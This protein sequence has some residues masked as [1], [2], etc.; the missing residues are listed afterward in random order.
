MGTSIRVSKGCGKH[1]TAQEML[2]ERDFP[3]LLAPN[4][5]FLHRKRIVLADLHTVW[6]SS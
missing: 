3:R 4:V 2:H 1:K 5:L 6:G